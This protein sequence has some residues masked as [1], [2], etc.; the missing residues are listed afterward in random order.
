MAILEHAET[1]NRHNLM[2]S[3]RPLLS[4]TLPLEYKLRLTASSAKC[5][6]PGRL[7]LHAQPLSVNLRSES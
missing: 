2:S 5:Y 6:C 3:L 7:A 1:K 4:F